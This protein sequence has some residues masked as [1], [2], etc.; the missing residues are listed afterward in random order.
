MRCYR[1][2]NQARSGSQYHGSL[3]LLC[4]GHD[5][6]LLLCAIHELSQGSRI[7][8]IL[9]YR[10]ALGAAVFPFLQVLPPDSTP[11]PI[12][13]SPDCQDRPR[14]EGNSAIPRRNFSRLLIL[15]ASH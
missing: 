13:R 9:Y 2:R 5:H 7:P 8:I 11:L 3:L 1:P 4:H 6:Y 14:N 10:Y 15:L 12:L